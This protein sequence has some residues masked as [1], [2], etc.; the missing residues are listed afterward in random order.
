MGELVAPIGSVNLTIGNS[1]LRQRRAERLDDGHGKDKEHMHVSY[2]GD[3]IIT[4]SQ[5]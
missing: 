4:Q 3:S 5:K 2:F 1:P